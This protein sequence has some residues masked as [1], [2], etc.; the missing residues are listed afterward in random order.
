[1][2]SISILLPRNPCAY[3]IL[4]LLG[5][6]PNFSP[7][8]EQEVGPDNLQN[9]QFYDS[10]IHTYLIVWRKITDQHSTTWCLPD[11][12]GLQFP[13]GWEPGS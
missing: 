11:V 1:M 2:A 13:A 12:F 7:F 4:K 8:S 9:F 10:S 5:I 6:K 3:M